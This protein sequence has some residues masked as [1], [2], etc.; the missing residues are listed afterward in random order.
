MFYISPVNIYST[1]PFLFYLQHILDRGP[2]GI[3][4]KCVSK[5]HF[6]LVNLV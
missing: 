2:T 1:S 4:I 3:E 5:L 6:I